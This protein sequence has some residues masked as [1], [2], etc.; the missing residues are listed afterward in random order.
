MEE[1]AL[2]DLHARLFAA[3][4]DAD[5]VYAE[6]RADSFAVPLSLLPVLFSDEAS[7]EG[8]RAAGRVLLFA[9]HT[10]PE[11]YATVAE[12]GVLENWIYCDLQAEDAEQAQ[13]ALTF[14]ADMLIYCDLQ[15]EDAEQAQLALTFL[16]DMLVSGPLPAGERAKLGRNLVRLLLD[17]A[18]ETADDP[19]PP[20]DA[21]GPLCLCALRALLGVAAQLDL[22]RPREERA[23]S[24]GRVVEG[25]VEHPLVG[26][27]RIGQLL[28]VLANRHAA[29][30]RYG[31]AALRLLADLLRRGPVARAVLYATD[32]RVLLG[33]VARLAEDSPAAMLRPV[34][35][36]V[37][38]AV[39]GR[40]YE[41]QED[42]DR[43]A[44]AVRGA[45]DAVLAAGAEGADD[46]ARRADKVLQLLAGYDLLCNDQD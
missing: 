4:D 35:R 16:A 30:E 40:A 1:R 10:W 20:G 19:P 11:L 46:L 13:L 5:P 15:A 21:L 37:R 28:V 31:D 44:R 6:L 7:A 38:A 9:C 23:A 26:E 12:R 3:T 39:R 36:V 33:V 45:R 27:G 29:D 42:L 2:H 18:L 34:L 25:V 8:R 41:A 43:A 22:R 14:L 32:M 24:K 17:V